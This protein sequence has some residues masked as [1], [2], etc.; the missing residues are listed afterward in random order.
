MK[1]SAFFFVASY[2]LV[3]AVIACE[4]HGDHH[5]GHHHIDDHKNGH[6]HAHSHAHSNGNEEAIHTHEYGHNHH[7]HNHEHDECCIHKA[8][9]RWLIKVTYADQVF[10]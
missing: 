2:L 1:I 4:G 3:L 7:N 5:H 9:V 6:S 8:L 10:D